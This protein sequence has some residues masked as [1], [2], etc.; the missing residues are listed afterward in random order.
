MF[1]L[2]VDIKKVESVVDFWGERI[3]IMTCEECGELI[4]AISKVQRKLPR[5]LDV[6]ISDLMLKGMGLDFR[7]VETEAADV[8]ISVLTL[9][10]YY[11]IPLDVIEKRVDEKLNKIYA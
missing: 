8:I 11:N 9:C 4:Q 10:I 6:D 3:P 7:N 2:N 1:N 5:T